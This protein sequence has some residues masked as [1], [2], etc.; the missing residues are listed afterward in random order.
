[1]CLAM[2]YS[3]LSTTSTRWLQGDVTEKKT[4]CVCSIEQELRGKAETTKR[5]S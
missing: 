5:E 1:M 4:V 3:E 2:V